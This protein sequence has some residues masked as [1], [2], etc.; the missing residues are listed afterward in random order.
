MGR[1][2]LETAELNLG[3]LCETAQE[4]GIGL[5]LDAEQSHRQPAIDYL[6]R[7]LMRRFN[8]PGKPPVIY[9]T[10]QLYL[11]G[12]KERVMRDMVHAREHGYVFAVKC[13]RGAYM[14]SEEARAAERGGPS[15]IHAS[16][17]D[18]DLAFDGAVASVL[19]AIAAGSDVGIAICTHNL[20][21]V[22]RA[23][24]K[25]EAL[26][27]VPSNAAVH[28]AQ[29]LG[30]GDHVTGALR[31]AQYNVHKLVLFGDFDEV[32]PWLL[33]RLDENRDMIGACQSERPLL[34]REVRRRLTCGGR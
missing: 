11:T 16:K 26:R 29:I 14:I 25:M 22:A 17:A 33:R 32:F 5:W 27:I 24:D 23:V 30:M 2:H 19:Q 15:P 12:A 34:V 20:Q 1:A 7:R 3:K 13:V 28:F 21:S 4:L 9:N 6:A 31:I 8:V 10:Y 18:T